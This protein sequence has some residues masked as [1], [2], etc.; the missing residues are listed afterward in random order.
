VAAVFGDHD[1]SIRSMEQEGLGVEARLI[2][3]THAARERDLRATLEGLDGLDAV[4]SVGSMLRVVG[5]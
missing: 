3:I 2:F 1:V 4:R 5:D